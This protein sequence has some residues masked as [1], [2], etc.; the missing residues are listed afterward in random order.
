MYLWEPETAEEL[1]KEIQKCE[2]LWSVVQID[3]LKALTDH[4]ELTLT[5]CQY[6]RKHYDSGDQVFYAF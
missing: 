3:Q 6:Y 4:E 5:L 2:G 1:T